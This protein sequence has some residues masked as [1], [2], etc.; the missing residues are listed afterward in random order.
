MS[1]FLAGLV[2]RGAG[3]GPA[4]E[5][6]TSA[7]PLPAPDSASTLPLEAPPQSADENPPA[8]AA[9][10]GNQPMPPG[11]DAD[12]PSNATR[13]ADVVRTTPVSAAPATP[14][15]PAHET[16]PMPPA[17]TGGVAAP[18]PARPEPPSLPK[19]LPLAASQPPDSAEPRVAHVLPAPVSLDPAD[20]PQ[21]APA[22]ATVVRELLQVETRVIE[23]H[24]PRAPPGD[25][26][27]ASPARELPEVRLVAA[28]PAT[29][30]WPQIDARAAPAARNTEPP[31]IHVRIGKVE[32]K[33]AA[34]AAAAAPPAKNA[35]ATAGL[36]FAAYRRLRTYRM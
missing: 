1:G 22:P 16:A 33:P 31:P 14:P 3:L 21:P 35:S 2:Q 13:A 17:N 12:E 23:S 34:P 4:S 18:A 5:P 10:P 6:A 8:V 36:G 26:A 30:P 24:A 11:H 19:A 7:A 29:R 15:R 27:V 20:S 25:A 32:V 9:A 28:A